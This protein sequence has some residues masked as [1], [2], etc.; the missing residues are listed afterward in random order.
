MVALLILAILPGITAAQQ[1]Q[2][3]SAHQQLV[4]YADPAFGF[5]L[6]VPAGWSYDRS[7]FQEFEES[8]GLLRGSA[9]A[10]RQAL[11]IMV[12][13]SFRMKP[14]E[15]WVVDFGKA[16]AELTRSARVDWET[17]RIPPRAGAVLS[18]R[19]K[20]GVDTTQSHYLCVPFDPH[21]VWVLVY[22]GVALSEQ[23]QQRLRAEFDSIAQS[24]KVHYDPQD[25]ER[26]GPALDRGKVVLDKLRQ[27][28]AD[29]RID[30]TEHA[31]EIM[32]AG[33]A[34]GYLTRR[35]TREEY[36]FSHRNAR[37]RY[38]KDGLRVRERS[39]RFAED[40]TV[41]H[42]RLDLFSSFDLRSELIEY[43]Q[44]QFPAPDV[45]PQVPLTK[46]DQV[47][48]EDDVLFSSFTTSLDRALPN[49]GKPVNVGPV[50]LDL[51]W[52]RLLPELLMTEPREP[53]AFAIYNTETRALLAHTIQFK[54]EHK[55]AGHSGPAFAFEI[56][57][58]FI[59]KPSR[60]YVDERGGLL[61]LEA[62]Q[63]LLERVPREQLERKY[64]PRRDAT[65]K[66]FGISAE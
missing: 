22:R 10:G 11:Q 13:R 49:P 32:V 31:F 30:D 4:P 45:Q 28:A 7:R 19:S 26:L 64:G 42:A 12:F 6:R 17:I 51:A 58:G 40:G 21:T 66:R 15:D 60:T 56:R 16:L 1:P 18:Y 14:F 61:R 47:I 41:R 24:L 29:V 8:I 46:T 5:E 52:V 36:T 39:W 43:Q 27:R 53:H 34:I 59:D 25:A 38:A 48:R 37:R 57:E 55:L 35:V 63:V 20:V 44:T 9:P 2:P 65:R 3:V 23:D 54:G 62:G 50:Y 33:E